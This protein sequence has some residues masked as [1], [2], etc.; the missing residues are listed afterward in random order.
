MGTGQRAVA[1]VKWRPSHLKLM[2]TTVKGTPNLRT[3][4][5]RR[6][7]MHTRTC[8]SGT[9]D[10]G[11]K[12]RPWST[13]T[14]EMKGRKKT[15]PQHSCAP[16]QAGAS[17]FPL[18][19]LRTLTVIPSASPSAKGTEASRCRQKAKRTR[20]LPARSAPPPP[21]PPPLLSPESHVWRS[22]RRA[23]A[24]LNAAASAT[25]SSGPHVIAGAPEEAPGEEA[26]S[27]GGA[28]GSTGPGTAAGRVA[29]VASWSRHAALS[30]AST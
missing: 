23:R 20:A 14:Q 7:L 4:Y 26:P 3:N 19:L 18:L 17:R 12:N 24:A 30:C 29:A 25:S 1:D 22:R 11:E 13:E 28:A 5:V 9:I 10:E 15:L 27:A 2:T 16:G 8:S 6:P 21:P